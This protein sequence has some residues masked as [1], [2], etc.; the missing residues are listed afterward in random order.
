[1]KRLLFLLM[2]ILIIN[3]LSSMALASESGDSRRIDTSN[4]LEASVAEDHEE[5]GM[6][7][8]EGEE[9]HEEEHHPV[10]MFTGW[11]T[12]FTIIA[13]GYF[14]MTIMLLPRIMAKDEEGHH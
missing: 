2:I 5:P 10:W 14:A 9:A 12:V 8:A 7:E 1:M 3:I 11:Q 4:V 6:A 13:V